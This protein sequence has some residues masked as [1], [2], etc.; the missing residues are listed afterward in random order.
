VRMQES[1]LRTLGVAAG[2]ALICSLMVAAAVSFF[3]PYQLAYEAV[4]RNRVVVMAAE[5]D[6]SLAT[7]TDRDVVSRFVGFQVRIADL[8]SHEFSND[9][10]PLSYDYEAALG[11]ADLTLAIPDDLDT[12]RIGA[13]PRYMP[14]YARRDGSA[15]VLPFYG[16]GMWSTV[17]GYIG[18]AGDLNT[19]TG[20]EI[21]SEEET[22][23][24]GDR[25]ES[26]DWL[27]G[28]RGKKIFD[29]EGELALHIGAPDT[30]ADRVHAVDG[31]TGATV[32]VSSLERS[33]RFWLGPA[34]YGP[35]L[36]KM[37]AEG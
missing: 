6:E 5:A 11:S 31:I 14:I 32:T 28:W 4:E 9:V 2:V 3:R 13:M 17:T 18:L 24:I 37:R 1:A 19:I 30:E 33:L 34:G 12:A 36:A 27:A 29:D 10:D 16:R 15:I 23:G 35:L 20:L 21:F 25:I 7:A 26:R 8:E 22:P